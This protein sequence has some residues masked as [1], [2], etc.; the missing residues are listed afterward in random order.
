VGKLAALGILI[1]ATTMEAGGD[2]VIRLGLGQTALGARIALF[3]GGT[4]LLFLYGLTLNLA[5][6]EFGKVIGLYIATFFVVWQIINL[7]V[8][9]AAPTLPILVGG[10]LIVA[11]GL[12]VTFCRPAGS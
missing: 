7:I 6:F 5:P 12:L 8:F 3:L 9:R 10:A 2:A 1:V 4:V 11:G